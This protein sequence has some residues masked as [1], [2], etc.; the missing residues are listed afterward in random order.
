MDVYFG[1][2]VHAVK[3]RIPQSEII[4][5][6]IHEELIVRCFILR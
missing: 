1:L 4:I 5:L 2:F 3:R 6:F